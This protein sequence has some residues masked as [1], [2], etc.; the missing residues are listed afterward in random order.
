MDNTLNLQAGKL[1]LVWFLPQ[2]E[3]EATL[4]NTVWLH[5]TWSKEYAVIIRCLH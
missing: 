3:T 4:N 1:H 5:N 2:Q